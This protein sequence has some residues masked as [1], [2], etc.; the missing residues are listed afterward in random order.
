MAKR[1]RPFALDHLD[2]PRFTEVPQPPRDFPATQKL[3]IGRIEY[4]APNFISNGATQYNLAEALKRELEG[5]SFRDEVEYPDM[6]AP[7]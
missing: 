1:P 2:F 7:E 3:E 4:E 6:L 5:F